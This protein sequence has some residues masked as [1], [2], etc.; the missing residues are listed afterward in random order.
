MENEENKDEK[1]KVIAHKNDS[2]KRLDESFCKHIEKK[3]YKKSDLLAYWI[4]DYSDYHDNESNFLCSRKYSR[5]DIIKVNLGFNIGS[6]LGGL[7]YCI[8]ISKKDNIAFNTLNVIP[9][10]SVKEKT[11]YGSSTINLGTELFDLLND[12]YKNRC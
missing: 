1:A 9:L 8:V 12:K 3:E 2:L 6:E 5:G 10:S 4:K 7:H 11:V